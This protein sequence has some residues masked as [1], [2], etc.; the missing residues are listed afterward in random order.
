MKQVLIVLV[1]LCCTVLYA[2]EFYPASG[3]N[4]YP[5]M[6]DSLAYYHNN[7]VD[8]LWYGTNSWAVQYDFNSYFAGF[9]INFSAQGVLIYI[10]SES[11]LNPLTV[12]LCK[13]N[14]NQPNLDSIYVEQTLSAAEVVSGWNE[15][16]FPESY[17]DD[18]F[19]LI[20]DYTTNTTSQFI[21]ASAVDGTHSFYEDE[22]YYYGMS[23]NGF[24]AEFLVSLMGEFII[25]EIDIELISFEI[26][27]EVGFSQ[28]IYP[29]FTV[30][31]NSEQVIDSIF[32]VYNRTNPIETI[33][34]TIPLPTPS[35]ALD[36]NEEFVFDLTGDTL[37]SYTTLGNPSQYSFRANVRCASD[38]FAYNNYKE[39]EFENFTIPHT[40]ILVENAVMSY[41]NSTYEIW[42]IQ[43]NS[44]SQDS[45]EVLNYFPDPSDAYYNSDS[46]DRFH[47][48]D[49]NGF[50]ATM[51]GGNR[52][53]LGYFPGCYADT[54]N[55]FY[56]S[57]FENERTY[58]FFDSTHS[59]HD[60][61]TNDVS[62]EITLNNDSTYVFYNYLNNSTFYA[63]IVEDSLE[64][65]ENV[66]GSVLLEIISEYSNLELSYHTKCTY[67]IDFN[68]Y[69]FEP[70]MNSDNCRIIY[71]IQNDETKR[72]DYFETLD[73]INDMEFDEETGNS[74]D[75][76]APIVYNI[77][78]Y[79]NPF[80]TGELLR[81]NLKSDAEIESTKLKIYNIKGQLV[82]TIFQNNNIKGEDIFWNGKD[83][84]GKEVSS[85]IYYMKIETRAGRDIRKNYKKCVYI[86]N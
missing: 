15:F 41:D 65:R 50:P 70:F 29:I 35:Y 28:Q 86:K 68:L 31:N 44:L 45:C 30:K 13:H 18:I 61:V 57:Y 46:C 3:K 72:I 26:N 62:I 19:W 14:V 34:D 84:N 11:N 78:V 83:N 71:W 76:F 79:P 32:V 33:T 58:M 54:L 69:G 81:I 75:T 2:I 59:T 25:D 56:D 17:T 22:G 38:S 66:C 39:L 21:A 47:Y 73:Y 7:T 5:R 48:Y 49:L 27:G 6:Q 63:A 10:P 20:F 36:P 40:K 4:V 23:A 12:K 67:D 60:I 51:V 55:S 42:D 85:G 8:Q 52:K 37:Y 16:I 77:Q 80:S 74:D 9:P 43:A 64:I 24:E 53:I 1:C 82:K